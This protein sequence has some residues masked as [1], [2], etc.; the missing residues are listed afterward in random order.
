MMKNLR[1]NRFINK[2][3]VVMEIIGAGGVEISC[4]MNIECE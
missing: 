3:E 1:L 2:L 4:K